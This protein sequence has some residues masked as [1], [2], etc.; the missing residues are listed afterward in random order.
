MPNACGMQKKLHRKTKNPKNQKKLYS[1]Y[2]VYVPCAMGFFI[3]LFY[4]FT[5]QFVCV[6]VYFTTLIFFFHIFSKKFFFNLENFCFKNRV[7]CQ[8]RAECKKNCTERHKTQKIRKNYMVITEY[9]CLVPWVFCTFVLL[10]YYLVCMCFSLF[11]YFNLFLSY[12]FEKIFFYVKI[13]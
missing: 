10:L 12:F 3:R 1:N 13:S 8:M 6:L 4:C 11:Y 5:I 2:C 9:M 7:K